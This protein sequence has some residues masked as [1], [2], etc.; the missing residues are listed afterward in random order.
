MDNLY[1]DLRYAV[2]ALVKSP[3]ASLVAVLSLALG[4][5]ANTTIF[6]LVNAVILNPLPVQEPSRLVAAYTLDERQSGG[7]F[8]SHLATSYPNFEDYRDNNR[9]FSHLVAYQIA[10]LAVIIDNEPEEVM[11]EAVSSGYFDMLGIRPTIGRFFAPEENRDP[12]SSPVTVLSHNFWQR[13]F[14]ADPNVLGRTL[15]INAQPFEIIGVAPEGFT[16][17]YLV[18]TPELWA[19]MTMHDQVLS[20]PLRTFFRER[21]A[22]MFWVMGRL[23][24][25][26]SLEQAEDSMTALAN[27]LAKDYPNE[28]QGRSIALLPLTQS[29]VP[30]AQRGTY[31]TAGGVLMAVVGLV[32]LIACANVAHLLMVRAESRRQEIS[33]RL[34]LGSQRGRLIRQ[35]LTEGLVLALIAGALGLLMAFL[36]RDVLWNLRPPFLSQAHPDLTFDGHV[37]GMT[38]ALSLF[39]ALL[40]GLLPALRA[41][42]ADLVTVLRGRSEMPGTHRLFSLRSLL[43]IFQVALSLV[44][45]IVSGLFLGSLRKA[46][47]TDPGFAASELSVLAYNLGTQGY[48]AELGRQFHR[49]VLDHA[50][51]IPGV[52]HAALASNRPLSS[53]FLGF[54]RTVI[55]E[56]LDV[57]DRNNGTLIT[58]NSVSTDYFQTFGLE[59]LR[60]RPISPEDLEDARRVAI[61]NATMGEKLWP[62]QDPVGRSFTL[63]GTDVF[64]EVVG[65]VSDSK[66]NTMGENPMPYV[67]LPFEQNYDERMH[68]YL[69]TDGDPAQLIEAARRELRPL[70]QG[71]PLTHLATMSQ[72]IAQSLWA[73]RLGALLMGIFGL[74]A[75]IM[76]AIGNYGVLSY[77]VSQRRR[78]LGIRIALGARPL[79]VIGWVL[80]QGMKLV[81]IGIFTGWLAAVGFSRLLDSLLFGVSGTDPV[82]FVSTGLILAFIA[83]LATLIPAIRAAAVDPIRALRSD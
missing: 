65:V 63:F 1:K 23:R 40:F 30:E 32:L 57:T 50:R 10:R 44:A 46:Q 73:P 80:Q 6:T 60:G 22:L 11:A 52:R 37:L 51:A 61:I 77:S 26:I 28:N 35:L 64:F 56:G 81:V 18:N 48:D 20:G 34:A 7:P 42:K 41:S 49:R 2:R 68:L 76:A 78:E 69:R 71:L 5:G 58:T 19:P 9:A 13:R 72:V 54:L 43:V 3:V 75:L 24:P 27:T 17:T 33:L 15:T 39:T 16:G 74:L 4:I 25:G 83:F 67:Y 21:R 70:D 8:G 12:G 82:V 38:L 62:D 36:C 14:G 66:Y 59:I 55:P 47:A 45:L 79:G 31:E 29:N 53:Q